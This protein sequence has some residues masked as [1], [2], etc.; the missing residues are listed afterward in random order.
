MRVASFA[1]LALAQ[2]ALAAKVLIGNDDGF[3][4]AGIIALYRAVKGAGH[5]ALIAAPVMQQSGTD[6]SMKD[7]VPLQEDG[8]FGFVKKG[9]PAEGHDEDDGK[10]AAG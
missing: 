7:P 10:R 4:T 2:S 3:K 6:G 1:V 5:D 8:E 9:A